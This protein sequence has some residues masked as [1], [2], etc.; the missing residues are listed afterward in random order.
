M[1]FKYCRAM[2]GK[3]QNKSEATVSALPCIHVV[4]YFVTPVSHNT[5]KLLDQLMCYSLPRKQYSFIVI[6][7]PCLTHISLVSYFLVIV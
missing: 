4:V 6:S 7:L 3:S 1:R 5:C 2:S